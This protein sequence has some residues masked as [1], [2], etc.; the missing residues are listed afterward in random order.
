MQEGQKKRRWGNREGWRDRKRTRGRERREK[1]ITGKPEKRKKKSKR[2]DVRTET[3]L[4][5]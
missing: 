3:K 1:G 4:G 5:L 2:G